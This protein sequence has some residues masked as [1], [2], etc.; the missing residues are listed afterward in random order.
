MGD[1]VYHRKHTTAICLRI[2][3]SYALAQGNDNKIVFR[4]E[5]RKVSIQIS[6]NI[7]N[8]K[9]MKT[10]KGY[11]RFNVLCTYNGSF[12]FIPAL[13]VLFIEFICLSKMH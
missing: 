5:T 12:D 13:H 6:E 2:F 1:C 3:I 9:T 10:Q 11:Q 4:K 8:W 7:T